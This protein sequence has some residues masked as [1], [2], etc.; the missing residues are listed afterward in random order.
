MPSA[1]QPKIRYHNH[2]KV[3]LCYLLAWGLAL[4]LPLLA[5]LFLYPFKLAGTAPDLSAAFTRLPFALPEALQ[6]ALAA[7]ALPANAD[8]SALQAALTARDLLW[9]CTV[10]ALTALG[11]LI[12][13][14][15]QLAWRARFSRPRQAARTALRAVRTYRLSM[16]GIIAVNLLL[17]LIVFW[18][19]VRWISQRTIWD[20]LTYFG[21][22]L[23]FPLA[24]MACF[25]LAAP[26]ALSG[27]R[28]FF[29]RL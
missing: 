20:V 17:A 3:L 6:N 7:S 16:L 13:L 4:L 12:S 22:F 5:L 14:A 21:G 19:G 18:V 27:K 24:A 11:W 2:G 10:G 25:R 29:R 23:L 26:A 1:A 28:A 9:R 15:W 8:I